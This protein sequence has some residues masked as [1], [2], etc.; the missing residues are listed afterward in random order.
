MRKTKIV[1]T[2]GPSSNSKKTIYRM[3]K[4]GMNVARLNFS[5]GSHEEHKKAAGLIRAGA[6]K[7]NSPVALLQD[8]KGLKIRTGSIKGGSVL[9]HK[10]AVLGIT[11][12]KITGN[13]KQIQIVYPRLVRDLKTGNI[14]LIDDG[15]IHL[16]VIRKEKN[17]LTAKV[18]EGGLLKEKKG[19]NFPGVD[20]TAS[21]FTSKDRDDLALGIELGVDYIALSFVR[22][23]ADILKVRRWLKKNGSDTPLIAK[24]ENRQAIENIDGIIEAS[25]GLMIARGDL[26]VEVPPEEV[27]LLQKSLIEKCNS[28]L[29]PVITATQMLESMTEHS[30]PTRAEAADVANAVIDGTD[31]L[32]LSGETAVGR[33]PVA[34]IRMMDKIIRYTEKHKVKHYHDDVVAKDF[35]Q[36]IAEAACSSA[37][38]IRARTIAAFTRSGFTALL[39]SK[40]RPPVP[41][42]G[43]TLNE[44]ICRRMNLYWGITP[45]VMKFPHDTD[46]MIAESE[47]ALIKEKIVKKGDAIAIIATSPFTLGGKTNILKLHRVGL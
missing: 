24:I 36:A 35:A 31:A 13:N 15:L 3:I 26:G 18:M 19:V 47:N 5:H 20:V 6:R 12:N 11:A 32:M 23:K 38:D 27:P 10:G 40:F 28:G 7:Y 45:H 44:G 2:I 43:F 1:C 30:R 39:V 17:G 21:T 33:F 22:S 8:I 46:E 25:D 4:T 42:T 41:I 14:I 29:K 9:L 16:K 34:T 37:V